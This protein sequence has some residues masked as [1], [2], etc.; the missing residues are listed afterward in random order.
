MKI[1]QP[2]DKSVIIFG[3]G[4]F[5][6]IAFD[7]LK[8]R[9]K[10]LVIDPS[11]N[12]YAKNIEADIEF[13]PNLDDF[14]QNLKEKKHNKDLNTNYAIKGSVRELSD[15]LLNFIPKFL[16]PTAPVH[17]M[18]ETIKEM[19]SQKLI[20]PSNSQPDFEAFLT[21]QLKNRPKNLNIINQNSKHLYFSYA[22]KDELCPDNCSGPLDY[23]PNFQKEKPMAISEFVKEVFCTNKK[24]QVQESK[25]DAVCFESIQIIP[26]LGGIE[27]TEIINGL[28]MI[29]SLMVQNQILEK[30]II[31]TTCNCHGV[32]TI[33]DVIR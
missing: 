2:L 23:C 18:A 13:F 15:I 14:I 17:V 5:G 11:F 3:F 12:K 33:Y 30:I 29:K 28:Q 21:N 20:E 31:S 10:C 16:I 9:Y 27:S 6:R 1:I 24:D 7:Y 26:G 19:Y 4:K 22:D 8:S 32:T 25:Y